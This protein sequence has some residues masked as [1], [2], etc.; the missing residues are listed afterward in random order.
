MK[1]FGNPK[2]RIVTALQTGSVPHL[3]VRIVS[4]GHAVHDMRSM[5]YESSEVLNG[6]LPKLNSVTEY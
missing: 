5:A 3:K 2:T 6:L 4:I 1:S